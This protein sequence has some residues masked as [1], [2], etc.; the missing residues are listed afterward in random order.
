MR[1]YPFALIFHALR[2]GKI[3]RVVSLTTPKGGALDGRRRNREAR[4]L[5]RRREVGEDQAFAARL[6]IWRGLE[7]FRT[8]RLLQCLGLTTLTMRFHDVTHVVFYTGYVVPCVSASLLERLPLLVSGF[9]RGRLLRASKL[10]N[11]LTIGHV[12]YIISAPGEI[13]GRCIPV[14]MIFRARRD[15]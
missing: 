8:S 6:S 3:T 1:T 10:D 12:G 13:K 15:G 4:P 7:V 11:L 2:S 9:G 5:K 14:R